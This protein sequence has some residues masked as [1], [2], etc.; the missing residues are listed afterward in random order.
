VRRSPPP[1]PRKRG[2]KSHDMLY[3]LS[4]DIL[5]SF[6]YVSE[7]ADHGAAVVHQHPFSDPL[8]LHPF[9]LNRSPFALEIRLALR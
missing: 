1:T 2:V 6:A 3:S 8:Q 5:Y 7:F 9:S 4:R